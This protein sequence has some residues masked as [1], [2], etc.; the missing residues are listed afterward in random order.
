M[1]KEDKIFVGIVGG[2]AVAFALSI[3]NQRKKFLAKERR[4]AA[5][6]PDESTS[7]AIGMSRGGSKTDCGNLVYRGR[8]HN[9]FGRWCDGKWT[10]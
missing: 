3:I 7:S 8:P 4:L 2:L 1:V 10:T 9:E 5:L 6:A